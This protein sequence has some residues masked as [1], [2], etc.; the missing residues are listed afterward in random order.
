MQGAGKHARILIMKIEF[1]GAARG[2]T[3][4]KHLLTV[5]NKKILLDCGLFQGRR[6]ESIEANL[7]FPFEASEIDAVV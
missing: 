3:G 4:S 6:K 2:V 1:S 5:N 7:K